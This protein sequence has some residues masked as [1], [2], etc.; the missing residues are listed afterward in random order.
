ME[1]I[2]GT[3]L[4]LIVLCGW[5]EPGSA[6]GTDSATVRVSLLAFGDVNLGRRVGQALL[7][8]DTLYPFRNMLETFSSAD[9]V[10][11]NL[12]SQLSDQHGETQHPK[13]NLIFTGPPEGGASLKRAGVTI[14]STANNHAFDYG[15]RALKETIANLDSSDIWH[16]GTGLDSTRLYEPLVKTVSGIRFAFFAVT[17]VMNSGGGRWRRSIATADSAKLYPAV[18]SVRDSVDIVVVS[19]HGDREYTDTPTRRQ[20]RFFVGLAEAGAD[21]VIGHHSHTLQGVELYRGHWLVYSLGNF[22]FAQ[23]QRHWTQKSAGIRWTFQRAGAKTFV[24]G[25]EA[26]PVAAG[27]QPA[28][29][30]DTT[31][32]REVLDRLQS[33]SNI[34]FPWS[35][36]DSTQ[37][38]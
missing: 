3:I 20:R 7:R 36:C 28:V 6:A 15:E 10:F 23:P 16:V 13:N 25:V 29:L 22:V 24:S 11:V 1:R 18:R 27:F 33:L 21:I 17:S 32:R 31:G 4:V 34:V 37:I 14:V 35:A 5:T 26:V 12:E 30:T 8:G 38:R 19:Y 9:L 2:R